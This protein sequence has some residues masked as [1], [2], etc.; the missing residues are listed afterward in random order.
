MSARTTGSK[1]DRAALEA[2]QIE[3]LRHLLTEVSRSNDFYAPRLAGSGLD[4]RTVTLDDFRA[5]FPLT[6]KAEL[7]ADQKAHPPYG[8]NLTYPLSRYTRFCQTSGTTGTPMRWLDTSESWSWMLGN[9]R[10]VY[11][12]AGVKTGD[13]L[14]FAFGFGPFLGFWTAFEAG[15]SLGCMC[16]PGGALSTQGRLRVMLD[17]QVTGLCCTPTYA[18]RLG[19]VARREG[20]AL[21]RLPLECIIVAGEPGGAIPATRKKI[22]ELWGGA[23]VVDH[24]GMTEVGPA[25]YESPGTPG[26]MHLIESSYLVEVL[27]PDTAA[28]VALGQRGELVLTTLGRTGSP[29]IRYRTGDLVKPVT[30]GPDWGTVEIGLE[31]GI[32]GR[33]DDMVVVRGVNIFPSAVEAVIREFTQVAEYRVWVESHEA[34]TELT[35]EIEPVEDAP[36]PEALKSRLAEALKSAFSLRVPVRLVDPGTLPRF[37]LKAKRW[38]HR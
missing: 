17:N 22:S 29:L 25:G 37:E 12:A 14:F 1:L 28:P 32:L 8:T 20:L 30:P 18:L 27:D 31:N 7:V 23:R 26:L 19:E 21:D 9:W 36:D 24:Y 34:M 6:T 4:P 38:Q 10:R 16:L 11:E 35:L 15:L 2:G 33:A 13:R 5:R 3:A